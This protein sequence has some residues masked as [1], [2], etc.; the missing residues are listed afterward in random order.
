MRRFL[1]SSLSFLL[2]ATLTCF[3]QQTE[4]TQFAVVTGYSY[5]A[6]PSLNLTQRGFNG[7]FAQNVRPWLSLG[8]DFSTFSGGSTL[9]PI[10]LNSATQLKL[11]QAIQLGFPASALARGIPYTSSTY[12]YQAGPQFNYRRFKKVTLFI[13]PA[14]GLLHA[15]VQTAPNPVAA[16]LV[17]GLMK[18]KLASAD[19][20]IFWGFGG[21]ATWEIHPNFGLRV[22]A[23]LARFN[24]FPDM[25]N[26][27]RNTVRLTVATKFGFGKNIMRTY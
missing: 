13:R 2:L 3:S 22:A 20:A 11:A 10:Y 12:T 19:N 23:D 6:T 8:F 18:G 15:K 16:T 7:D 21:G 26:G 25:L 4:I 5:L 27:S 1:F 24:F 14:L 17:K 9:L